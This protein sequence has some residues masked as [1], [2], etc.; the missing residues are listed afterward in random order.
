M[1]LLATNVHE[2]TSQKVKTDVNFG[3]ARVLFVTCTRVATL[4]SFLAN[5]TRL[6]FSCALLV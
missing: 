2:K 5:Q 4:Y 1:L 3:S 6:I